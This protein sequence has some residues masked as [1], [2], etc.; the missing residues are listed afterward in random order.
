MDTVRKEIFRDLLFQNVSFN[1]VIEEKAKGKRR[2]SQQ[3]TY[4]INKKKGNLLCSVC[5]EILKPFV[6]KNFV[7]KKEKTFVDKV[8][9]EKLAEEVAGLK[10]YVLK[11]YRREGDSEIVKELKKENRELR[12]ELIEKEKLIDALLD[13][14]VKF[15]SVEKT[16]VKSKQT[17]FDKH[18]S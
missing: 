17:N 5:Q 8:T 7:E 4:R 3:S 12:N 10:Q 13:K 14:V 1:Y 2:K 16:P 9:L 15:N 11:N 18:R 6:A